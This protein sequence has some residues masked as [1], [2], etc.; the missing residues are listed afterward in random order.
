M[1]ATY[2]YIGEGK[3]PAFDLVTKKKITTI[4]I[5]VHQIVIE[6]L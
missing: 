3:Q 5:V 1:Y 6:P 4:I 2:A